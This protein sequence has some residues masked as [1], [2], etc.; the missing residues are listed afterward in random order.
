MK[1]HKITPAPWTHYD[2]SDSVTNRHEIVAMGKTVCHI[3]CSVKDEDTANAKLIAAAPDLYAALNKL[4]D[5]YVNNQFNHE[6]LLK[7]E[8]E[9]R[10]ALKKARGE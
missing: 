8:T 1:D 5:V 2:D 10:L 3:Y 7:A 4:L 9:A 6:N